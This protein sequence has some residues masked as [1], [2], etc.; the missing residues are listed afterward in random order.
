M[1]KPDTNKRILVSGATGLAGRHLMLSLIEQETAIRAMYRTE[2]KKQETLKFLQEQNPHGNINQ[3]EWFQADII[4]IPSLEDAFADITHVYHCAG[5]VS[6]DRRDKKQLRKVNIEGTA[7]M[8][9]M[10]LSREVEKFCHLSSVAALGE[11]LNGKKIT[12]KSERAKNKTYNYY[13][14]SK[15]GAEM[16]VWRASQEGLDVVIVNPA[17]IIGS[18]NWN[19]GSGRLFS[20]ID[21]GFPFKIP[22]ESGFIGVN[23]V[24]RAMI[25]FMN[26]SIKNKNFILVNEVRSF[27]YITEKIAQEL[28]KKQPY[29]QLNK[30]LLYLLWIVQ[31]IAYLFG[32]KKEVNLQNINSFFKSV[33]FDNSKI[34]KELGFEYSSIEEAIS[35][36]ARQYIREHSK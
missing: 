28:N 11:E 2:H 19:S 8:V 16:E 7:N 5:L 26:S 14:I 10:A 32:G 6:F 33:S 13:E 3:I 21:K 22:K 9:N 24:V 35:E 4:D 25:Q 12:E 30:F 34:Q 23:D 15:F 36:T 20:Q 27:S 1:T 18:G 29:I 17:I 31:S